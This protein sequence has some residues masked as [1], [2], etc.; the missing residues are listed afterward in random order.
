MIMPEGYSPSAEYLMAPH[1][2][3]PVMVVDIVTI[4]KMSIIWCWE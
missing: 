3:P 1:M 2:Q 4:L